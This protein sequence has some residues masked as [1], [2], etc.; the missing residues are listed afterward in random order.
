MPN[1]AD[2]IFNR[3]VLCVGTYRARFG[4]WPI[5]ARLHPEVLLNIEN[6]LDPDQFELLAQHLCVSSTRDVDELEVRGEQGAVS[7]EDIDLED[8]ATDSAFYEARNWLGV[9]AH[10]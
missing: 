4:E 9:V 5:E 10:S 3:L 2:R 7:Y 8:D 1:G 6:L